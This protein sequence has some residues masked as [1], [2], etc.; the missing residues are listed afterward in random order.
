MTKNY[1]KRLFFLIIIPY[2]IVFLLPSSICGFIFR[3]YTNKIQES[4][5]QSSQ[6]VVDN[7]VQN[8][9]NLMDDLEKSLQSLSLQTSH[10]QDKTSK[11][12]S[13]FFLNYDQLQLQMFL[14]A[15]SNPI[16]QTCYIF[17]F[18]EN[19]IITPFQG[20]S[21]LSDFYDSNFSYMD[22][23]L[24][25]FKEYFTN[26]YLNHE[27][28]P[29]TIINRNGNTGNSMLMSQSLP[30]NSYQKPTGVILFVLDFDYIKKL[31]ADSLPDNSMAVLQC[32]IK[33]KQTQIT[34]KSVGNFDPEWVR[35]F[36][37]AKNLSDGVNYHQK[38]LINQKSA[39]NYGITALIIQ[40]ANSALS[41]VK[42]FTMIIVFQLAAVILIAF[43]IMYRNAKCNI[44]SVETIINTFS[45]VNL[46][47]SE[48]RNVYEYIQSAAAKTISQ[49]QF[50]K[51]YIDRQKSILEEAFL[52]KLIHGDYLYESDIILDMEELS[53]SLNY[54]Y[55]VAILCTL[56]LPIKDSPSIALNLSLQ[57]KQTLRTHLTE[58]F[59]EDAFIIDYDLSSLVILVG[60]N[61]DQADVQNQIDSTFS[62][63]KPLVPI[64]YYADNFVRSLYDIPR[65]YKEARYIQNNISAPPESVSWYMNLYENNILYNYQYNLYAEQNL[66]NQIMVGSTYNVE[67]LLD[68]IYTNCIGPSPVAPKLLRCLSY[69]FYRLANHVL[70]L[71]K[72]ETEDEYIKLNQ[73]FDSILPDDSATFFTYFDFIKQV[74]I[75]ISE[76]N[77]KDNGNKNDSVIN[78]V[79]T[80]ISENYTDLQLCVSNIAE[81][82]GISTKYLS[83]IFKEQR[84]ENISDH[85]EKL[86]IEKACKLLKA[87]SLTINDISEQVGYT[88][89][90]TFRAAFKRCMYITPRDYRE[91]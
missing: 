86:R 60:T 88:N 2:L 58:V 13:S 8:V 20:G 4:S 23:E 1:K 24:D 79:L 82:C 89:P 70:S 81:H 91:M 61:L 85:I 78:N 37:T 35:H 16:L 76:S 27:L 19:K 34:S 26:S 57:T 44:N 64:C 40:P 80:Y 5:E 33:G 49:N 73:L 51:D 63:I 87:T 7:I 68:E 25:Q 52:R 10:I 28:L 53:L 15:R 50:L 72:E 56:K 9:N 45:S 77:K 31:M 39:D 43:F 3:Q 36:V 14:K 46:N 38:Y 62:C 18:D 6:A 11:S 90:H 41:A 29:Y 59:N 75:N 84:H 66:I 42:S 83:Q 30:G 74:C 65:S 71:K 21:T 55:Y 22:M 12:K 69:D 48:M 32:K 17:L 54:K 47:E 67:H